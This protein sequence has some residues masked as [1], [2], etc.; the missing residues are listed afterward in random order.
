[1]RS[2]AKG[3][4]GPSSGVVGRPRWARWG[5]N[6]GG[7]LLTP[8]LQGQGR[9]LYRWRHGGKEEVEEKEVRWWATDRL[10]RSPTVNLADIRSLRP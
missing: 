6:E 3:A 4:A 9:S 8:T 2:G 10:V 5:E 7:G 1:M